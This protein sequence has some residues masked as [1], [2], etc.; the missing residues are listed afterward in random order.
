MLRLPHSG[1]CAGVVVR[2]PSCWQK[3]MTLELPLTQSESLSRTILAAAAVAAPSTM[4]A[5]KG[6]P[7]EPVEPPPTRRR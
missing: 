7:V 2:R 1:T 4:A 6:E 5:V 3:K